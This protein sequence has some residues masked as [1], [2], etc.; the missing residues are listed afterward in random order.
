MKM[1]EIRKWLGSLGGY[2]DFLYKRKIRKILKIGSWLLFVIYIF[3]LIDLLFFGSYRSMNDKIEYNLVPFQTIWMYI[4]YFDHFNFSIWFSNL[5]GNILAFMPLGFLIPFLL[6]KMRKLSKIFFLSLFTT[7]TVEIIQ[8]V[9]RVGGFDVD[10]IQLNTLGGVLG[11]IVLRLC[12]KIL[13]TMADRKMVNQIVE[14]Q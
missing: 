2:M 1:K 5:V 14:N 10:D 9:F 12:I 7:V 4:E 11:Y 8:L 3:I 13:S 6:V